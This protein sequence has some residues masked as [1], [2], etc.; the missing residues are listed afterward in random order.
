[1][2]FALKVIITA[3]C[4]AVTFSAYTQHTGTSRQGKKTTPTKEYI[5]F[6]RLYNYGI[7]D[8]LIGG[9][10]RGTL[11]V[12][13]LKQKGNFGLGAPDMI[14]GELMV[15]DGEAYQ[16]RVNGKTYVLD[17]AHKTSFASVTFFKADTSYYLNHT[18]G[19]DE[20]LNIIEQKLVNKNAMYAIRITGL[21]DTVKTR[22]FP[23]VQAE[24]FPPLSSILEKQ[25]FFQF[26][27]TSG[28]FI[29]FHLPE[30]LNGIN[31]SGFHF[32][33]LSDNKQDGG[34][35][36]DFTSRNIKIE[37]ATL[38]SM[39]LGIPDDEAFRNFIFKKKMNEA[40]KKVEE[41]K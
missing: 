2:K 5:F 26:T 10:Y 32:H 33:Y 29:G 19:K 40:L 25:Q 4:I 12:K 16:T 18:A 9:L 11:S 35:I 22:A 20:V 39:E 30:Y 36:I 28:T 37:M 13:D 41:G 38:T 14:D 34:H 6:N 23:P 1:M 17:N 31:A 7:I 27:A 15:L 21:F 3:A 24:P 8:G